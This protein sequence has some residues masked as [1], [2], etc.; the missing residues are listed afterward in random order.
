MLMRHTVFQCQIHL[1]VLESGKVTD[2]KL[3]SLSL[4]I[5]KA[6][7]VIEMASDS[8][9]HA[10]ACHFLCHEK[11]VILICIGCLALKYKKKVVTRQVLRK[12]S[13]SC[14]ARL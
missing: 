14:S 12:M 6:R 7:A 4:S 5:H 13:E 3:V 2:S 9:R 10:S 1:C 11:E 8:F